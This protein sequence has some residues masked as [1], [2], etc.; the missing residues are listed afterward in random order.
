MLLKI[1][2][3]SEHDKNSAIYIDNHSWGV[4]SD[5]TLLPLYP[6]PYEGEIG[7]SQSTELICMLEAKARE[8]LLQYLAQREH[9]SQECREL[10]NR[11]HFHNSLTEAII[12]DYQEKKFID[13]A[14][15]VRLYISSLLERQK[16][17]FYIVGKLRESR[18]ATSLWEDV[19]QE[20]YDPQSNLEN[21][22]EQVLKLRLRYSGLPTAKQQEKIFASLFRK[23]YSLDDIR[24][25]WRSS[26]EG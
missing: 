21:L 2:K 23:G 8:I 25:A 6:I 12:S 24:Q 3:K 1:L 17:R 16:S 14:R 7:E 4:L 9:S 18:L 26:Q 10:L 15:Y 20:L 11:K 19:L 13:D 5:R 22:K